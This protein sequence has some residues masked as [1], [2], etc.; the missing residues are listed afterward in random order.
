MLS[1]TLPRIFAAYSVKHFLP[2][3]FIFMHSARKPVVASLCI[4]LKKEIY[5]RGLVKIS[6]LEEGFKSWTN[7]NSHEVIMKKL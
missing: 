5:I 3:R 6:P 4:D 1:L 7:R 2:Y